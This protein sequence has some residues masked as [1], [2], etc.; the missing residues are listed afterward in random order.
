[1]HTSSVLLLEG[2]HRWR[3]SHR[4][5]ER[6]RERETERDRERDRDCQMTRERQGEAGKETWT[7]IKTKLNRHGVRCLPSVEP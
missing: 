4:E 2:I 1:M 5:I 7:K 3:G 6:K